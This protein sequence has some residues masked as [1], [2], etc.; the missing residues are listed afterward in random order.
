MKTGRFEAN[1]PW[2]LSFFQ[3]LSLNEQ[4]DVRK[5]ED[6]ISS[7]WS[8][9][10]SS[11]LQVCHM[12][13]IS[14][15]I[16]HVFVF[17]S[18][19][20]GSCWKALIAFASGHVLVCKC[21]TCNFNFYMAM[22][23]IFGIFH[24]LPSKSGTKLK[25]RPYLSETEKKDTRQCPTNLFNMSLIHRLNRFWFPSHSESCHFREC[26]H[27]SEWQD[28]KRLT[29][30]SWGP[31]PLMTLPEAALHTFT[32]VVIKSSFLKNPSPI[33]F[34]LG[35]DPLSLAVTCIWRSRLVLPG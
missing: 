20:A 34:S 31:G 21:W 1:F 9:H 26:V 8:K 25:C 18:C 30:S 13:S 35:P 16:L 22:C 4:M 32:G 6:F 11:I 12:F 17:Y 5:F 23:L 7:V 28:G 27:P 14:W 29:C 10:V 24:T 3:R 33:W 15:T 2:S 19:R